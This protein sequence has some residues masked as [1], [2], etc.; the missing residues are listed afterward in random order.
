MD[1]MDWNPAISESLDLTHRE[2]I[3]VSVTETLL[4]SETLHAQSQLDIPFQ[5]FLPDPSPTLSELLRFAI[6]IANLL[7]PSSSLHGT[8]GGT[9]NGPPFL[10]K[11]SYTITAELHEPPTFF[12]LSSDPCTIASIDIDPF[13]IHDPRTIP[14]ILQP[15]AKRWRSA[16]GDW[17]L[18]FEIEISATTLGPG[19]PFYFLYRL[20]VARRAAAKGIRVGKVSLV[21]REHR[22]VGTAGWG[23]RVVRGSAEILRWDFDEFAAPVVG[24]GANSGSGGR[25]RENEDE[26]AARRGDFVELNELRPRRKLADGMTSYI[27]RASVAA[28]GDVM[29]EHQRFGGGFTPQGS[30][31]LTPRGLTTNTATAQNTQPQQ[32]LHHRVSHQSLPLPSH[33]PRDPPSPN[34]AGATGAAGRLLQRDWDDDDTSS[35]T[36]TTSTMTTATTLSHVLPP[37]HDPPSTGARTQQQQ[38]QQQQLRQQHR[39]GPA[40]FADGWSG[41]PGGDGLYVENEVLLHAPQ[42]GGYTPSSPR[43]SD[44][45]LLYPSLNPPGTPVA[46]VEVKHSL[47]VRIQLVRWVSS[48]VGGGGGGGS[49]SGGGGGGGG[50]WGFGGSRKVQPKSKKKK[51]GGNAGKSKSGGNNKKKRTTGGPSSSGAGAGVISRPLASALTAGNRRESGSG[52]AGGGVGTSSSTSGTASASRS[53]GGINDQIFSDLDEFPVS[54]QDDGGGVDDR[55]RREHTSDNDRQ[56]DDDTDAD[57]DDD[58]S[59]E[60]PEEAEERAAQEL[61]SQPIVMECWCVLSSI[62]KLECEALLDQRPEVMPALD[63]DKIFGT[64]VVWVPAYEEVDGFLGKGKSGGDGE[65]GDGLDEERRR[66]GKW[67]GK[68]RVGGFFGTDDGATDDGFDDDVFDDGGEMHGVKVDGKKTLERLGPLDEIVVNGNARTG[69]QQHQQQQN[70]SKTAEIPD[71]DEEPPPYPGEPKKPVTVAV[72][73]GIRASSSRTPWARMESRNTIAQAAA[74]ALNSS[75]LSY[76][77]SPPT[78]TSS[79]KSGSAAISKR[80]SAPVLA[81]KLQSQAQLQGQAQSQQAVTVPARFR[82]FVVA[83]D[84]DDVGLSGGRG[85]GVDDGAGRRKE[86]GG[87]GDGGGGM[88]HPLL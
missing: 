53:G 45:S 81:P 75:T 50:G 57:D 24:G 86:A 26:A 35:V 48:A 36:T 8:M 47:Q 68:E 40:P 28:A 22:T 14:L 60:D 85:D 12:S 55:L 62:G 87:Q 64:D 74:A 71:E 32:T 13:I 39:S 70:G 1:I 73:G 27:S 72:G 77:K 34:F 31:A 66:K 7:P 46:H 82:N 54:D 2:K 67:K 21:L 51:K 17:P 59:E 56:S 65:E 5:L 29:Y 11:T 43:P 37:P 58:I 18:E 10:A 3:L 15:D 9:S 84:V 52:S 78:N 33:Q 83:D 69:G 19:D 25:G 30:P 76:A 61:V 20:A 44:P 42:R 4:L 63:Y 6:R 16:P 49:N 79:S 80:N 88:D 23:H 38:Q 41:G